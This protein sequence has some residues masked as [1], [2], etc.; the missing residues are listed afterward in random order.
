MDGKNKYELPTGI[1]DFKSI[2]ENNFYYVDKT[3][4]LKKLCV[5]SR[6]GKKKPGYYFLS[7]PRRFGKSLLIST[8][9]HL[10]EGRKQLFEGLS[11]YDQWN[12]SETHPVIRLSFGAGEF[13]TRR[14][15]EHSVLEQLMEVRRK[16]HL[17]V[18]LTYIFELLARILD[19]LSYYVRKKS[20]HNVHE[21]SNIGSSRL[22]R[23]ILELR[24]KTGKK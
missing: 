2:R 9:Q 11:I 10:F 15:I 1:D 23:V 17:S 18:T 13:K 4:Y 14:D 21:L 12:F 20:D 22:R 8:L 3:D 19:I 24:K 5:S 7:R 6:T 16:Y